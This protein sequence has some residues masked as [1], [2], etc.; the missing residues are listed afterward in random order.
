[1]LSKTLLRTCWLRGAARCRI[2]SVQ[3]FESWA[4]LGHRRCAA[5]RLVHGLTTQCSVVQQ[6]SELPALPTVPGHWRMARVSETEEETP[7]EDQ[8]S[9]RRTCRSFEHSP[10]QR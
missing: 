5:L 4:E 9:S 3:T 2:K 6:Y 1:M 8:I 7:F 10:S